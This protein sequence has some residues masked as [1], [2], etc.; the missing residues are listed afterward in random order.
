M[1]SLKS[2][3]S[4]GTPPKEHKSDLVREM[5]DQIADRYDLMNDLITGGMHRLWKSKAIS[6][7]DIQP[8]DR[9]LDLCCGSGD[10]SAMIVD[11]YPD[12]MVVGLDFSE[13]MLS[14]ARVKY[15][16]P[17]INFQYGDATQLTFQDSHFEGCV[18]SFGLRNVSNYAK[19]L[20]EIHRVLQIGG[21]VVILDLS[22]PGGFWD[23]LTRPFRFWFLPLIGKLIAGNAAAYSYLPNSIRQY[24]NQKELADLMYQCGFR[25][26]SYEN[27]LGGNVALHIGVKER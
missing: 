22:Y 16:N 10:L 25:Q 27:I 24:L 23:W 6:R 12:A 8:G 17:K 26:I 14:H 18:I 7:L 2:D 13:Q 9:I 1:S 3:L 20:S 15:F 4:K 21:K 11:R 19:C 5:F